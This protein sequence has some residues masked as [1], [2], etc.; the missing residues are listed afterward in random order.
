MGLA[1]RVRRAK[2]ET[3]RP[4]THALNQW[5]GT[6]TKEAVERV[7][8]VMAHDLLT[9]DRGDGSGRIRPSSLYGPC[10]R[11]KIL[12]FMGYRSADAKE[13][14]ERAAERGTL[15]HYLWQMKGLSCGL[16]TDIELRGRYEPWKLEGSIDGQLYDGSGFE[17]K[18]MMTWQF[19]NLITKRDPE[20][21]Q[22]NPRMTAKHVE[23]VDGYFR[24]FGVRSFSLVY[25]DRNT[26]DWYEHRLHFDAD[27]DA[28]LEVKMERINAHIDAGTMPDLL[29]GCAKQRGNVYTDCLWKEACFRELGTRP[30]S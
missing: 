15:D 27:R 22:V 25:L 8:E 21:G 20:T 1:D 4:V 16:M 6:Y 17:L 10:D 18:T 26:G 30:A 2:M 19:A 12:S 9:E 23:Q 7:L 24:I 28:T 13:S 14:M 3:D 29:H 5:D 11:Q